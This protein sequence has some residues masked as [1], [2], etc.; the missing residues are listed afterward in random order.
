MSKH[1]RASNSKQQG[2]DHADKMAKKFMNQA[3]KLNPLN[4]FILGEEKVLAFHK[5]D[6]IGGNIRTW[7]KEQEAEQLETARRTLKVQGR[8]LRRFPQQIKTLT[9]LIKKWSIERVEGRA[10]IFFIFAVCDWLP[11]NFRV[12]SH[13]SQNQNKILCCLMYPRRQS[14]YSTA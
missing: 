3:E 2:N 6:L 9:K 11:T 12:H 8:L 10:W 1:T 4:Y 7:L 14:I 13:D 5:A